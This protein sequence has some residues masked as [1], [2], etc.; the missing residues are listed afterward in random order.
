MTK[1]RT[2]ILPQLL[3]GQKAKGRTSGAPYF[4][5]SGIDCLL[6]W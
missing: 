2:R 3:A 1:F 5:I 4:R 6:S